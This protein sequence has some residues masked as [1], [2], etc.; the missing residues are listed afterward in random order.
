MEKFK[1]KGAKSQ[2]TKKKKDKKDKSLKKLS[3]KTEK[4]N[5]GNKISNKKSKEQAF[6][7]VSTINFQTRSSKRKTLEAAVIPASKKRRAIF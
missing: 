2:V 1:A 5:R 3:H 6:I 7:E 4:E